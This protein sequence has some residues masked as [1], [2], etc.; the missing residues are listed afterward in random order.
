MKSK[1]QLKSL[2]GF[3]LIEMLVVIAII[4]ILAGI[5]FPAISKGILTAKR[6]R[7]AAEATS[8]SGAIEM[9]YQDYGY[10]PVPAN[11][12]G[13]E[14]GPGDG[15]F[16]QEQTAPFTADESRSIIQV[17]IA[18]PQGY[19]ANHALNPKRTNYLNSDRPIVNGEMRDPWGNQYRIK[20]DRDYNGKLEY[21]SDPMQH[22]VRSVVVS[23]GPRGWSGNEPAQ[24]EEAVANVAL[25]NAHN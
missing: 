23:A 25:V 7:A 11:A 21:Y 10:L 14:P 2:R 16:G 18:D 24:P 12:Q 15:N 1:T 20:L 17:L 6:N 5:L 9:F 3:T 8:I 19:N 22:N 4:A 13:Y